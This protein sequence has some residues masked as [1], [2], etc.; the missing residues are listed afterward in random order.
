MINHPNL[1]DQKAEGNEGRPSDFVDELSFG[2]KLRMT[3]RGQNEFGRIFGMALD[4]A[5]TFLPGYAGKVRTI[6][7]K[8]T[9]TMDK[10]F[11]KSKSIWGGILLALTAILQAFGVD[12]AGD[13]EAMQSIYHVLYGLAG[14]LGVTGLRHAVGKKIKN[15]DK[16]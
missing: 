4:V 13:P 5:E 6:L 14:F 3:W 12:L 8:T 15:E 11:F 9:N 16:P 2:Q 1:E 10:P 7:Q